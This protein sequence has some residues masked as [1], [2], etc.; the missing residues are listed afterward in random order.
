M[1]WAQRGSRSLAPYALEGGYI[2]LLSASR[3]NLTPHDDDIDTISKLA[4]R[5]DGRLKDEFNKLY[6]R[7]LS[8][9]QQAETRE[10]ADLTLDNNFDVGDL[11]EERETSDLS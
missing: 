10:Q 7:A 3:Y 5:S 6:K 9:R 4:K 1:Q 8:I 2:N 11:A